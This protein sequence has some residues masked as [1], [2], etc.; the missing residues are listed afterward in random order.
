MRK[1]KRRDRHHSL[2]RVWLLACLPFTLLLTSI[3]VVP[4][5]VEMYEAHD[6]S[7]VVTTAVRPSATISRST[8]RDASRPAAQTVSV[9]STSAAAADTP[10]PRVL[11]SAT[12]THMPTP[13]AT[14][15]PAPWPTPLPLPP[16]IT[17]EPLPSIMSDPVMGFVPIP[18][19]TQS[20]AQSVSTAQASGYI[21]ILMYHYLR[22]VD[23]FND[24]LGYRLSV[25]PE[26][27]A[28]QLNWLA[29]AGYTTVRMETVERCLRGEQIC[30]ERAIALTFDDGYIDAH[31]T[32]LPLLQEHGFVATF[33]IVSGFVGKTGYMGWDELRTLH[34]AGMEIGA[35]SMHHP[36]LTTLSYGAAYAEIM[37]SRQQLATELQISVAS[38]CY[39]AGQFNGQIASIVRETGFTNATT[40]MQTSYQADLFALPRLRIDGQL[41]LEEFQWLVQAYMP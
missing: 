15:T 27:F 9:E 5:S 16:G 37:G 25:A 17:P 20:S 24:P 13:S 31:T 22:T 33:Y 14:A 26:L 40:T 11:A 23:A 19:P 38:F 28:A 8:E 29:A 3:N 36:D 7:T 6:A 4:S 12:P 10:T 1:P 35:H 32:A 30:P 41:N 39:P 21:P 2:K 34:D 18:S